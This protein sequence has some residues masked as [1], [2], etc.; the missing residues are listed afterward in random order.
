VSDRLQRPEPREA[1]KRTLRSQLMAQAST[2]LVRRETI[3]SRFQRGLVRPAFALAAVVLVLLAG[4]GK[5][6]A[7]SLPGDPA[8]GLKAAAEE[9]QLAFAFDDTTRLALLSEDADHRLAEL[10]RAL[11][12]HSAAAPLANDE[13]ARAVARFTAAV[14]ALRAKPDSS[15]DKRS[16]AQDVVDAAHL[17]HE[18][19]LDELLKSAPAEAQDGLERAKG[20]A[21]KLHASDR[22]ARTPEPEDG[23]DPTRS[24]QPTRTLSP[25]TTE[26]PRA[27]PTRAAPRSS[28]TRP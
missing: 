22:P 16:A 21:D 6:A 15:A 19:I 1:F 20:E 8:F 5:A 17:K 11:T 27:E 3:W 12:T 9:L 7:D 28:P 2:A 4:A 14:D 13:Y 26:P 24:P 10:S 18:A 25:R 23:T